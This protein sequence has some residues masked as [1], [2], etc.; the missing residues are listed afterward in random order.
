MQI[1]R[2]VPAEAVWLQPCRKGCR[3]ILPKISHGG[4]MAP[5]TRQPGKDPVTICGTKQEPGGSAGVNNSRMCQPACADAVP[6]T[7]IKSTY[8]CTCTARG[9]F[10]N[11]VPILKPVRVGRLYLLSVIKG[12]DAIDLS[13]L[14]SDNMIYFQDTNKVVLPL[15]PW[16]LDTFGGFIVSRSAKP[17]G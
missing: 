12:A 13:R 17:T 15:A 1:D 4:S 16:H 9:R 7:F 6:S 10:I 2:S 14:R 5:R 11:S 3:Q 8:R